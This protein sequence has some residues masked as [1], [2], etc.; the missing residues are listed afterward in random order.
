MLAGE[1]HR[2]ARHQPAPDL[3]ELAGDGIARGMVEE[4]AVALELDRVAA[5]DDIDQKAP[6]RDAVQ[7]RR[8][9]GRY[10]GLL[11]PGAHG[12]EE[13]HALGQRDQRAGDH[14]AVLAAPPSRQQSTV[15]A[16]L[17]HRLCYPAQIGEGGL[18]RPHR[19]AEIAPVTV[20]GDEPEDARPLTPPQ[21]HAPVLQ[22][23]SLMSIAFGIR[24][25]L[26]K[27]SAIFCCL[28][29]TSAVTGAHAVA[30]PRQ[31][32]L[33]NRRPGC[34]PAGR[35]AAPPRPGCPAPSGRPHQ[36]PR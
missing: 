33:E 7:R 13:T 23:A 20:G 29:S 22:A 19:R 16:E 15:I 8:H 9:A 36:A 11:Q 1:V 4:D 28:A 5:G 32:D 6:A 31:G 21:V 27:A 3:Q 17:V 18:A 12:H 10:R 24:P 34:P 14:P 26:W 35:S 25:I 30:D 2:L